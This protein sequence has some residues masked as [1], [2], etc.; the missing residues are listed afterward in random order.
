MIWQSSGHIAKGNE[1]LTPEDIALPYVRGFNSW[2]F[3]PP[4]PGCEHTY[5]THPFKRGSHFRNPF[6]LSF[7]TIRVDNGWIYLCLTE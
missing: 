5:V 2:A 4:E 6:E 7:L 1:S 3:P